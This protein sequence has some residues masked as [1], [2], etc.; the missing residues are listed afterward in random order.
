MKKIFRNVTKIKFI[1][2][3]MSILVLTISIAS[4]YAH[5]DKRRGDDELRV[6]TALLTGG[7]EVPENDSNAF[8]VAFLT[9]NE[10]TEELCYSITFTDEKLVGTETAAH[11]HAPAVPGENAPVVF[12]ITPDV[13]PLGS[14]KNGCV[15]PLSNDQRKQLRKGLFYINIHSETFPGGEIRG[16]VIPEK[17]HFEIEDEDD[18][19]DDNNG[20]DNGHGDDDD[21]GDR[22]R[23]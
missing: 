6:F 18:D 13:S 1:V 15:G 4:L 19:D 22:G 5:N 14:P 7:Q 3:I 21:D 8:G 16:Q 20:D 2:L 17:V 23:R 11:F 10:K 9:F 12:T